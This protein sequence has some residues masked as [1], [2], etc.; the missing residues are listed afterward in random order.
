MDMA[1]S[2]ASFGA[3]EFE[4]HPLHPIMREMMRIAE[5]PAI[6]CTFTFSVGGAPGADE[7]LTHPLE[8]IREL[9]M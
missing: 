1:E 3:E 7:L 2:A 9:V 8:P 4:T 6:S 5:S